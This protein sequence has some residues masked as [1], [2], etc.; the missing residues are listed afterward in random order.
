M[1]PPPYVL[2]RLAWFDDESTRHEITE[3]DLSKHSGPIVIQ[4]DPGMG[5]TELLRM[6]EAER[7]GSYL[8]AAQ[9]LR[10]PQ[11]RIPAGTLLLDALDELAVGSDDD[12][13]TALLKKLGELDYPDFILTCRAADWQGARYAKAIALDYGAS[14]KLITLLPIDNNEAV[15]QLRR[16]LGPDAAY[17]FYD[18]LVE[19]GLDELLGNPQS[20]RML[21]DIARD[22]VPTSRAELFERAATKMIAEHNPEHVQ[23]RL[24]R[25]A[26]AE[27]LD[28]AGA[29]MAM[30]LIVGKEMLFT[31]LQIHTP[32]YA[33]HLT[34]IAPLPLAANAAD[35][36]KSRLFRSTGE[37]DCFTYCH[38][39]VAEYLGA[40]WLQRIVAGSEYSTRTAGRLLALIRPL[41]KV[42]PALR[43]LHGWLARSRTLAAGVLAADAYGA[44]RYG[45]LS[46]TDCAG[47]IAFWDAMERQAWN[48]PWFRGGDWRR[49]SMSALVQHGTGARLS[50][51][52]TK[53]DLSQHLRSLILELLPGGGCVGE[54]RVTLLDIVNDR[55]RPLGE[56][57][58]AAAALITWNS[59]AVDWPKVLLELCS[60]GDADAPRLA[61][62]CVSLLGTD[63]FSDLEIA[64]IVARE[65]LAYRT[66]GGSPRRSRT[67]DGLWSMASVIPVER[68]AAILDAMTKR[69]PRRDEDDHFQYHA[70]FTHLFRTLIVRQIPAG[71]ID[72]ISLWRWLWHFESRGYGDDE[73]RGTIAA[74]IAGNSRQRQAV[75]AHLLFSDEGRDARKSSYLRLHSLSPGL[76]FQEAD[77]LAVLAALRAIDRDDNL[78][79][80]VFGHLVHG[81]H[82]DDVWTDEVVM[83]AEAYAAGNSE[84]LAILHPPRETKH[85]AD[86]KRLAD[87]DARRSRVHARKR[88]KERAIVLKQS[89]ALRE[90]FGPA[91]Q[92]AISYLGYGQPASQNLVPIERIR[93]WLG[94]D[95]PEL[96]IEGFEAAIKRPLGLSLHAFGAML[97]DRDQDSMAWPIVAGVAQRHLSGAGF[98]DLAD[99]IILAAFLTKR[100]ALHIHDKQLEGFG[101]ALEAFAKADRVRFEQTLRALIE[102]ALTAGEQ[103][104]SGVHYLLQTAPYHDLGVSLILEWFDQLRDRVSVDEKALIGALLDAPTLLR[105][106]A[107]TRVDELI[108]DSAFVDNADDREYW[109]SLRF[110]RDFEAS[111]E[112]LEQTARDHPDFLWELQKTIGHSRYGDRRMRP[113]T[114]V[115]ICW[116]FRHFAGHW[117]DT[118]HPASSSGSRHPW[119]AA[120]FLRALL[121]EIADRDDAESVAALRSLSKAGQT[122]YSESIRAARE[123]QRRLSAERHYVPPSVQAISAAIDDTPPCSAKDV[124]TIVLDALQSLQAH[125]SGSPID[126]VDLFYDNG[127]PKDEKA[128]RNALLGLIGPRL[129]HGIYWTS[130][131][132]MPR[133]KRAD[134]GFRHDGFCVPMEAKLAWH[135]ALW[136]AGQDQLDRLYASADHAAAGQGI[137]LV[138]W[139]GEANVRGIARSPSGGIPRSADDLELM[140]AQN[141]AADSGDRLSVVVIDVSREPIKSIIDHG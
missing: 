20:L 3:R 55:C 30:P 105:S 134:A 64:E 94:D 101:E 54:M 133:E 69:L 38:R 98:G 48:D 11:R 22:G 104:I 27:L 43:G 103:S 102:P 85:D 62:E 15:G 57:R 28:A 79:R 25:I 21:L 49:F 41:G 67:H 9:F 97:I 84:L 83:T 121:F 77:V 13:I 118:P 140:L 51:M 8:T 39:T 137:Y 119:D 61:E 78:A 76:Q 50:A 46:D 124:K 111:R 59:E 81:L 35:V 108:A 56:R 45:D 1:T 34:S 128:C 44:V 52:L 4:G 130:E 117:P 73:M 65:C 106:S 91:P 12:P 112:E 109:L 129:P 75:Q 82:G 5:K 126:S 23:T 33:L 10:L 60:H 127:V 36:L 115:Q 26:P 89:E 86:L 136:R 132:Q 32:D 17:R 70:G 116:I 18:A 6:L 99:D 138:F 110:L 66:V 16:L 72:A 80:E 114:V 47:A 24:N 2:R 63:R 87:D 53:P 141:L 31:G 74:W 107:H 139:F 96:A 92:L 29:A 135:K 7:R 68:C 40:R 120:D 113:A 95:I 93:A 131:P 71:I 42:P 37:P 14:P 123:K 90:G 58:D 19:H 100:A 122:S 125:L 88:A